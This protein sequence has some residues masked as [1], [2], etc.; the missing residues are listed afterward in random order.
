MGAGF[1]VL[2]ALAALLGLALPPV[3]PQG[4]LADVEVVLDEAGSLACGRERGRAGRSRS[5]VRLPPRARPRRGE[6]PQTGDDA[7]GGGMAEKRAA[8]HV[9][10]KRDAVC[11]GGMADRARGK[12]KSRTGWCNRP[13]T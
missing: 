13:V 12:L 6:H 7:C 8:I 5:A 9:C 10:G 2:A 1:V 11:T 3:H 4:R